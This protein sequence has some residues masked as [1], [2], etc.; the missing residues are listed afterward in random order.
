MALTLK[1]RCC[2]VIVLLM[3]SFQ[4]MADTAIDARHFE[5]PVMAE[6][7]RDLTASLRCP[8]CDA[9]AIDSS[10]SP[11]AADMRERV[12]LML[13]EGVRIRKF[14]ISWLIVLAS[15]FFTIRA[16]TGA[17][18]CFGRCRRRWWQGA[19]WL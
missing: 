17:R 9:Q 3:A 4:S 12:A 1:I 6:R 16:L 5:D 2:V 8:K 7:Y 19:P 10:D 13:H 15:S 11:V 14:L 18:G